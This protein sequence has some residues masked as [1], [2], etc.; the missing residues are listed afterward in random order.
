MFLVTYFCFLV[1]VV[2]QMEED[3]QWACIKTIKGENSDQ[4]Y[5]DKAQMPSLQQSSRLEHRQ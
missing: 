4:P 3:K 5:P 1:I 2:Y